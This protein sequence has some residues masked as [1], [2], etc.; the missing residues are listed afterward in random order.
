MDKIALV[1]GATGQIGQAAVPALARD[2]WEVRAASRHPDGVWP[3]ELGV[4]EVRL[5]RG[6]DA[7][8][9]AAVGD[10]VDVVVD[11]VGYNAGH[12]EQ[13]LKLAGRIGSAVVISSAAVYADTAGRGLGGDFPVPIT[14][15]QST[16]APDDGDYATR[17]VAL[18]RAL[19]DAG[20][21]LP[22][23]VLR[24]AAIHGPRSEFLREWYFVRRALDG[25]RHRILAHNGENRFQP[26]ATAN[27]AE[28]IRLAAA[29]PGSRALNAADPDAPT[30]REIGAAIHAVLGYEAEE[31]LIDGP[32]PMGA[33][34][35]TP[36]SIAHP[37]VLDMSAA[38]RE[39]GYAPVTGYTESLPAT[40]DWLVSQARERQ[41]GDAFPRLNELHGVDF[42]DYATEDD[43]LAQRSNR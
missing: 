17:K 14:E 16:M 7:Q 22:T 39:L 19:L 10:G 23:T 42:F 34:G 9:A 26:T 41:G 5:D 30:V 15:A 36:W 2:G 27:L 29:K 3:A 24:P 12:A 35:E 18:E 43:W 31:V 6:D 1:I 33:V 38:R 11:A 20:D 4:R 28:L 25:R 8:L 37:F 21:A 32:P 40:V 13:L